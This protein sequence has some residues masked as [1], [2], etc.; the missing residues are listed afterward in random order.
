MEGTGQYAQRLAQAR[1]LMHA[2]GLDYLVIGP[3]ADLLYLLGAHNRPSERLT[4][5]LLPQEGP[6]HMVLPAFEAATLPELPQEVQV[7]T[8]DE[9]AN[10]ARIAANLLVAGSG[11]GPGGMHCTVGV[12]D[13]LWSIFLIRLQAELPRAAFTSASTVLTSMRQIKSPDEIFS[14]ATSGA[15]ADK[16]FAEIVRRPFIGRQEIEIAREIA[17][18]LKAGGLDVEGVPIVASGP[19]SASPHHH[20]CERVIER[21]DAIVLDFGGTYQGYFS[22]ITRTLFAGEPPGEE[23][24]HVYSLVAAAQEAAITSARPGMTCESLDAVARGILVE[25]GYGEY[26]SHRLGHGIGLEGHEPPYMVEGNKTL[27]QPNMAFSVEPGLYLP[28]KLGVRIEDTVI[29]E[30]DG[31]RRLNNVSREIAVVQ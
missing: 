17:D 1:A 6:A 4:L 9:S 2:V 16:V 7:T 26:F 25:A 13:R 5:L 22:D 24:A 20:A 28:G 11:I 10:P 23:A 21:G 12:S 14:L 19:N 3:S 29:L 15:V 27:L 8:W 18:L 30:E 31:A